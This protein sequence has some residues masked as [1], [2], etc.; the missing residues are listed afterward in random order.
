[1]DA[2]SHKADAVCFVRGCSDHEGGCGEP[3]VVAAPPTVSLNEDAVSM[4]CMQ[5]PTRW[6]R[7][8]V[9]EDTVSTNVDA[10][11]LN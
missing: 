1:M 6:M 4:Q 3:A 5:C 9:T 8:A 10:V 7:Y 11:N 2:V